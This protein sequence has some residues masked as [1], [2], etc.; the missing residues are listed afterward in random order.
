MT[1]S[2]QPRPQTDPKH[3]AGA[4]DDLE[5]GERRG[6]RHVSLNPTIAQ[7]ALGVVIGA[8]IGA[9]AVYGMNR[10]SGNVSQHETTTASSA[11]G[12]APVATGGDGACAASVARAKALE[13]FAKGDIAALKLATAPKALPNLSFQDAAGKPVT[14]ADFK[15]RVLLVN[16]WATWCVPCRKEMPELDHLEGALGG[17]DFQVM[18]INLDTRDP[19]K[20]AAF[21][22][23][24]GVSHLTNFA[25]PK[26]QSF[27][28]LRA[29]GRGFGLPTTLLVDREGCELGFLAGPAAWGGA[30]AQALVKAAIGAGAAPHG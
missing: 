29:V 25:D 28:A 19:D 17:P 27:Q 22:K 30:D 7:V 5:G 2:E 1:N 16:L 10:L 26:G 9:L 21:L 11:P 24:I 13:P 8:T 3:R 14:L 20:P 4:W 18:A 6:K 12:V 15:G 23:E